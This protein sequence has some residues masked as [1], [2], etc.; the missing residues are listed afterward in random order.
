MA[1]KGRFGRRAMVAGPGLLLVTVGALGPALPGPAAAQDPVQECHDGTASLTVPVN[2]QVPLFGCVFDAFHNGV[3]GVPVIWRLDTTGRFPPG[4]DDPAHFVNVPQQVTGSD[5]RAH[6]VVAA[7]PIAAGHLTNVFF[8][9]DLDRNGICDQTGDLQALFQISWV[10]PR[11]IAGTAGPDTLAGTS[12]ADCLRGLG[13]ADRLLGR[14]GNDVLYGGP[15]RDVLRGGPGRDVLF[16]GAGFDTCHGSAA[17]DVFV[18]CE[19]VRAR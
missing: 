16:G 5:G 3:P 7:L 2:D 14:A 6:A 10:G 11:C 18:G 12:E 13:G 15:G 1:R 8:C 17:D 9:T 4:G 19:V